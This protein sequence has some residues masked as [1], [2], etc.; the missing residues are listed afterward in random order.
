MCN[1]DSMVHVQKGIIGLKI[2]ASV[3]V[4]IQDCSVKH[5]E[6]FGTRGSPLCG[7]YDFSIPRATLRGYQGATARGLSIAG[8]T[9]VDASNITIENI[10][11]HERKAV[12]IDIF[13]DS[14]RVSLQDIVIYSARSLGATGESFGMHFGSMTKKVYARRLMIVNVSSPYGR[15][16]AVLNEGKNNRVCATLTNG[17]CSNVWEE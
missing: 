4:E 8:S 11:S 13:T 3:H 9:D 1:G 12:G 16:V 6:N 15:A 10:V 2:D 17:V 5:V 14:E 7:N